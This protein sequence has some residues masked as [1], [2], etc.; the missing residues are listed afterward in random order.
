MPNLQCSMIL[1][2]L[3]IL[4]FEDA[5]RLENGFLYLP[6]GPGHIVLFLSYPVNFTNSLGLLSRR[7]IAAG[8]R[9]FYPLPVSG[10]F[11]FPERFDKLRA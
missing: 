7:A 8:P 10:L 4:P 11:E 1:C 3:L 5:Q 6:G 2:P 9:F